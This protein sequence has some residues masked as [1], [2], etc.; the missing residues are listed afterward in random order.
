M[1]I[2]RPATFGRG[3]RLASVGSY[4]PSRR[5]SNDDLVAAGAPLDAEE[6]VRLSGVQARRWV[7]DDEA[8]SDLATHAARVA[9]TR[10][11]VEAADVDRLVV[12]TVSPDHLSPSAACF[13]HAALGLGEVP[14]HDLT[15]S[16]S[17]F[18]YALELAARCVL[19][20]DDAV[21]AVAADVRSR[22]LDPHDRA[23]SA[24]FGDGAA[25]ALVVPGAPGEGL[26]ALGVAADGRGAKSVYVPSGGSRDPHGASRFI[27]MDEGPK[28]YLKAVEGMLGTAE[29]LLD[30]EGLS[31]ADVDHVVP[32]QPNRRILDR[33]AR[34]A[35][36]DA[37]KI[38]IDIEERGNVSGASVGLALERTL[39]ERAR[40][41]DRVLIVAAG[42]GYTAGAA[43]LVV[44]E[45]LLASVRS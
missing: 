19:T 42:A 14:A 40:P 21:L 37:S 26:V 3:V 13:A 27:R 38:V 8:T 4:L 41:G 6:M 45:A 23:T 12:A 32:H 1:K 31:F 22:F 15:A 43:L 9:M 35:G 30:A 44:D 24:L 33:M 5:V 11:K 17:G 18:V 36:I 7:A 25:S 34:L 39:V 28:V 20:G 2:L 16:C 29:R 10:A